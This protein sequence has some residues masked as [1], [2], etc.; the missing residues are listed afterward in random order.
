MVALG[1]EGRG[2]GAGCCGGRGRGRRAGEQRGVLRVG[3][4]RG[5]D[6]AD[7]AGWGFGHGGACLWGTQVVFWFGELLTGPR[8]ETMM[9]RDSVDQ[10]KIRR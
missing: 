2:R 8:H 5:V 6:A 9:A 10:V 1:G 7:G 4:R 3:V